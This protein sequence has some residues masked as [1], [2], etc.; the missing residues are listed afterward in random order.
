MP[1]ARMAHRRR[2]CFRGLV[3]KALTA[4]LS[5]VVVC[6]HPPLVISLPVRA[7]PFRAMQSGRYQI[8][9]R[10]DTAYHTPQ[11]RPPLQPLHRARVTVIVTSPP[12]YTIRLP[13]CT[14]R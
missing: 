3:P 13:C 1:A 11:F 7:Y 10:L 4:K 9:D 12:V 14:G 8:T 6:K 2:P 5:P